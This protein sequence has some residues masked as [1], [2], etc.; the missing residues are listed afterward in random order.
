M[1]FPS[2]YIAFAWINQLAPSL[3]VYAELF[4]G[5]EVQIMGESPYLNAKA[6]GISFALTPDQ[7]VQSVFLYADGIED[8][9][10][11]T[12]PLPAELSFNSSRSEVR[13]AL[14]EPVFSA[15]VGG[16]GLMAIEHSFDRFE[17]DVHYIRFEYM[18]GDLAIRIVTL[19]LC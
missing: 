8:F 19:G 18:P 2:S 15:E 4:N 16:V 13:L 6:A 7:L 11:Y 1:N 17:D 9:A 10:Q 14:G 5:A 3:P 12:Q